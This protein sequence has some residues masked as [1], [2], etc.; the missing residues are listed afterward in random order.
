MLTKTKIALSVALALGAVSVAQ[1]R[2]N[3]H[4]A[5]GGEAHAYDRVGDYRLSPK[6]GLWQAFP[7][8]QAPSNAPE[9][10]PF[11]GPR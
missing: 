8:N 10:S 6:Q 7:P 9:W 4:S 3:H 11:I 1:A 2:S 5:N